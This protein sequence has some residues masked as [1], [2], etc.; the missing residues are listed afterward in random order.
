MTNQ[1]LKTNS[2]KDLFNF[3]LMFLFSHKNY[4]RQKILWS[5]IDQLTRSSTSV[6]ANVFEAKSA[7]SRKDYI[8]Y[9]EIALKSSN[10]TKYWLIII[11]KYSLQFQEETRELYKEAYEISNIIG[12]SVLTLK[13]KK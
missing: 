12:A 3:P 8:R 10:E 5:L 13:G 1:N 9:F 4:S 7:S 6:G 2:W 11:G